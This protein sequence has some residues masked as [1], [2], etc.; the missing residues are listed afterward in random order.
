[1]STPRFTLRQLAYFVAAARAGS[2]AAAAES[3]H[4]SR[5][6]VAGA[7]NELEALFGMPLATRSRG[8]GFVLTAAGEAVFE[9]ALSLLRE[10]DDLP[11]RVAGSRLTGTVVVGSFP[12]VVPTAFPLVFELLAEQHPDLR[13][14]VRAR[15]QPELM[16]ALRAGDLD[17]AVAYN[18]H[19]E[20][21]LESLLVYDTVMHVILAADH[22][23]AAREV[24]PASELEHERLIL[25]AL[26]PGPDDTLSY[27]VRQG[28]A[29][30]VWVRTGDFELMRSLVARRLGVALCIQ[31][32]RT[33]YSY[34]GLSVVQ[35]PLDPAPN[36]ERLSVVWP[37]S[38]RLSRSAAH[39]AHLLHEHGSELAPRI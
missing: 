38:R 3:E 15:P 12:S 28:L 7:V 2:I 27:F 25:M 21:D 29:P 23:L 35:R 16:A 22:P 31:A 32:P 13:L 17:L 9:L 6:V 24:V 4:I 10:A 36:L 14:D 5:S 34:E 39:V 33:Q 19:L 18:V 1:M 26:P 37:R 8:A 30:Q 20:H 11:G